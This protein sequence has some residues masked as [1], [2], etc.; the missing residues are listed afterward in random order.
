MAPKTKERLFLALPVR[1]EKYDTLEVSFEDCIAGRWVPRQNLHLT[2]C[3]LGNAFSAVEVVE[4]LSQHSFSL[5]PATLKGLGYFKPN[6]ILYAR[7]ESEAVVSTAEM[8]HALLEIP[9]HKHFV[10]HVTLLRGKVIQDERVLKEKIDRFEDQVIGTA[11]EKVCL[12][13]S[14]LTTEGA[15]YRCL[16]MF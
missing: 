10:S 15:V 4:K 8:L 9:M 16:H 12:Y 1:I 7:V 13:S 11:G 3:F 6:K 5:P 2:L 14:S